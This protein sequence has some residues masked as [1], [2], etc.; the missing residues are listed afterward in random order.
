MWQCGTHSVPVGSHVSNG[1]LWATL[2]RAARMDPTETIAVY[3]WLEQAYSAEMSARAQAALPLV[4]LPAVTVPPTNTTS[5]AAGAS[6]GGQTAANAAT[7]AAL[8][9]ALGVAS[10]SGSSG[11]TPNVTQLQPAV[12]AT[13]QINLQSDIAEQRITEGDIAPATYALHTASMPPA[14]DASIKYHCTVT[15]QSR[16]VTMQPP[17]TTIPC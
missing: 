16:T 5:S 4:H 1:M 6:G 7:I 15:M 11:G 10:P 3:N 12:S 9:S 8:L 13:M 2:M 14:G 17:R